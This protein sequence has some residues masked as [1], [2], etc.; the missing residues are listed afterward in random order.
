MK[1][2]KGQF[3]IETLIALAA[4]ILIISGLV[5]A[6]TSAVKNAQFS[7]NQALATKYATEG[8]EWV[9]SQRDQNWSTFYPLSTTSSPGNRYCISTL[10]TSTWPSTNAC[11]TSDYISGPSSATVFKREVLLFTEPATL[12]EIKIKATITV[13]WSDAGGNHKSNLESYFTNWQ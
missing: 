7:K 13:S 12:P 5:T 1:K 8:M 3:L 4:S 10:P 11:G 6:V 2:N 9:R